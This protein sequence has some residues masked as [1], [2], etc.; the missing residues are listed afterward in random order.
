MES[1]L[2]NRSP[3]DADSP[4]E[5]SLR[6]AFSSLKSKLRPPFPLTILD[7]EEEYSKLNR[8]ILYG[9]LCEPELTEVHIKHLH[10]IVSDAYKYFT[11]MLVK[12]VNEFYCK[13]FGNVKKQI[14]RMT[15]EMVSVSAIGFDVL[16]VALLR[17][18]V[19]GDFSKENSWLC[20]EV[21]DILWSFWD[22]LVEEEP[23]ILSGAL[24]VFMRLLAD[25][26]RVLNDPSNESLMKMEISFCL[27]MLRER[28]SIC[29]RIGRDI[30]RL[31]QDLLSIPEFQELWRDLVC[32][33]STFRVDGFVDISQIYSRRTSGWYFS[34]RLTPEMESHLRF[35]LSHVKFGSQK[36]YQVWFAKKF[37]L[38][39]KSKVAIDI[40][41]FICCGHH[42]SNEVIGSDVIPR[43]AVIGWLLHHHDDEIR[44]KLKLALFY[45]W[46]FFDEGA[47]DS[48]MDIEP[49]V[50][51][52][53]H[54]V[55][56]YVDM[57]RSL[58]EFVV[59][60]S[61]R[62]DTRRKE[63]VFGGISRAFQAVVKRG[64]VRSLDVVLT[65][66]MISPVLREILAKFL[67][68]ELKTAPADF[69]FPTTNQ[70]RHCFTRYIEFHRCVAAKGED[71][72]ECAKFAN[73]YRALCPGEWIEKW[74][75]QRE[76]GT[77]PGPL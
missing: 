61:D 7:T 12:V 45:D 51:L 28:F 72:G 9:T 55:P 70:T 63:V 68:I 1:K 8:A 10:G 16:L 60:L 67:Q 13:T 49:A 19:G 37:L 18:I 17:Q 47:E 21:L 64:V 59:M 42:P 53:V 24:Y 32:N 34:L 23:V 69:R 76:S 48:V 71:S 6:A 30:V 5:T 65:C 36:R 15:R 52:M 40:V 41:R 74:N 54:S 58:V 77:F 3:Y 46:L 31:L 35:L 56:K 57:T 44:T 20:V 22:C 39:E 25:Q 27:R 14:L 11:K 4:L 50:L 73:Y 43:W 38:S 62:Y 29:L 2:V 33:P 66:D 75:E 26:S